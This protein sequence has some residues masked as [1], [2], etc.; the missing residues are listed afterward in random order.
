LFHQWE[1][2]Y[3]KSFRA[4]WIALLVSRFLPEYTIL[5]LNTT[6][7]FERPIKYIILYNQLIHETE[8]FLKS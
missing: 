3:T 4:K 6:I 2:N 5:C 1:N 8:S 7:H